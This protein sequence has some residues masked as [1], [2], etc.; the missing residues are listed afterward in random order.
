[1][2]EGGGGGELC[3]R[4][5]G[6]G[7]NCEARGKEELGGELEEGCRHLERVDARVG[8]ERSS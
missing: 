1:V 5:G 4:R 8:E 3:R 2:G 7:C 6:G